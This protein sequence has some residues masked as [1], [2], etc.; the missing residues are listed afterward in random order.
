[1]AL[2][3]ECGSPLSQGARF[4]K[5][6]GAPIGEIKQSTN[7]EDNVTSN[8]SLNSTS[9]TV[10]PVPMSKTKKRMLAIAGIA[11]V[12]LFG[13]YKIGEALT[14]K[15]RLIKRFETALIEKDEEAVAQLLSSN[16][17]KLKINKTMVKSFMKYLEKNPEEVNGIIQTLKAQSRFMEETKNN[18]NFDGLTEEYVDDGLVNLEKDGKILFYDKYELNIEPVYLTIGT[19]YKGTKLYVNGKEI[20]QSNK[21]NYEK[22]FGPYLP[23]IYKLEA[24]LKTDYVELTK[25]EEI[26]LVEAGTKQYVNLDLEAEE[27]TVDLGYFEEEFDIE[28]KLLINGKDVGIN[29]WKEPTFGPVLTDG[30][31]KLSV[32][33]ALPWGK[34][35]TK[36]VP[37]DSDYV[38]V[39]LGQDENFQNS[40]MDLIVKHTREL[41]AAYTSGDSNKLT[42]ATGDY[43]QMLQERIDEKKEYGEFYKG[44]YLGTAF[45]L[46]S[47]N[48]YF[49]DGKWKVD[50][51]T[52]AKYFEDTFYEGETPE[53]EE[54]EYDNGVILVY[55]DSTK[56]WLVDYIDEAYDFDD[57]NIKEI[58]EENPQEYVTSWVSTASE[59]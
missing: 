19:N 50:V 43:K 1:M 46:D 48:V 47:F 17:P 22:T 33:A 8:V 58:K 59:E 35:K 12:I 36:E 31:M 10:N 29:P 26:P 30:S 15:D 39:N 25:K 24:K 32:E 34:I 40:I 13:G 21:P 55:D 18:N 41:M 23:G 37:I 45:D 57:E 5:E 9:Q 16:D 2:C 11:V 54:Y 28:A 27:V 52:R 14:S 51:D 56:S 44:K 42:T 38:E 4:C 20:G 3:K 49:E 7:Q 6:C 53:L